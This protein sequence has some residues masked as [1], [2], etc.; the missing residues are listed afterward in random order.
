MRPWLM[1]ALA[2]GAWLAHAATDLDIDRRLLAD[3]LIADRAQALAAQGRRAEEAQQVLF[4]ELSKK[5]KALRDAQRSKALALAQLQA[6]KAD[7]SSQER[8]R[9]E[10]AEATRQLEANTQ[11]RLRLARE[12][13]G[14]DRSY[15]AELAEYRRLILGAVATPN[16]E[17]LAALQR[18]ADGERAQAFDTIAEIDR[19]A[20]EARRKAALKV[21]DLESAKETRQRAALAMQMKDRG[22]KDTQAVRAIW[23][24]AVELDPDDFWSWVELNRSASEMGDLPG[25]L[26]AARSAMKHAADDRDRSVAMNE[27]GDVQVVAG[28]LKGARQSFEESLQIDRR[29]A[30]ANPSSAASQR[31]L[32]VSLERLGNVQEAAGDLK[33]ARQSFEE[34]LQM[35]QRLAAANPSSAEAQRDVSVSLERLGNVQEAAGDLK[36]AR[37]SFDESLQIARR[38]AAANPSSAAAQRDLS[39]SLNKLGE[40]QVVAGDLKGARQS[41]EESHQVFERLAAANPSS[42]A[43][44]R[45]VSVSLQRLGDVQLA[46]GDLKGAQQSFEES[47]QIAR[48][49]AAAN[50]SSAEA[51]RDVAVS[52]WRLAGMEG[53][54]VRWAEVAVFL[55]ALANRGLLPPTDER[56][57]AEAERRAA[58]QR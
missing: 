17:R 12:I 3:R 43:P 39:V 52:M 28:D 13:E 22:E 57:V 38:L 14:R 30:A 34:S 20:R 51:Q 55:R 47:L 15:Q 10:L 33:G 49:L 6:A 48:R 46:A 35:R 21:V 8:L 2:L 50:P 23:A 16:P 36:G 41:F 19:I 24:E 40:V 37:Q 5:D 26:T 1:V 54:T 56:F 29:L 58:A 42:A 31:D 27:L 32:S 11:E 53:A 4:A 7:Q 25:A 9:N 45:D 44:Q 18:F